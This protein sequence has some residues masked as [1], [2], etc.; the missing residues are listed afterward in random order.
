MSRQ[1]EDSWR[2]ID[3][4]ISHA[5]VI[6][7]QWP[8]LLDTTAQPK[9]VQHSVDKYAVQV[10][11]KKE[12][13]ND[14]A[15]EVGEYFY[16]LR[17]ALDSVAFRTVVLETGYDP[18]PRENSIEFPIYTKPDRFENCPLITLT[19]FPPIIKEWI[20]S[21]QPYS[22]PKA[23]DPDIQEMGRL[24]EV[25]HDCARKDRHRKLHMIVAGISKLKTRFETSPNVRISNVQPVPIDFFGDEVDFLTF[26]AVIT[27][28]SLDTHVKLHTD[29]TVDLGMMEFPN[30]IGQDLMNE[31]ERV[32]IAARHVVQVFEDGYPA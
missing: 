15:L 3:R 30:Q 8:A 19:K 12:N 31:L 32:M 23:S 25:L 27:D 7:Q 9:I 1:F 13:Q 16:Q 14:F 11:V 6:S 21:V 18:P 2:R 24:L 29:M 17:A 26:D 4:A 10:K 20:R 28:R 22:Y 5:R